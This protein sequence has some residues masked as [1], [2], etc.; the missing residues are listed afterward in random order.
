MVKTDS[1]QEDA[2]QTAS[3][4]LIPALQ[5]LYSTQTEFESI[6]EIADLFKK[7]VA[8]TASSDSESESDFDHPAPAYETILTYPTPKVI[9]GEQ[10]CLHLINQKSP[11]TKER[12]FFFTTRIEHST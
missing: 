10:N 11:S 9:A 6:S 7:G 5:A 12:Y 8:L 4:K 1:L 2:I 3:R